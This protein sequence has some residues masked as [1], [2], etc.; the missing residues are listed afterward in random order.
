MDNNA[1]LLQASRPISGTTLTVRESAPTQHAIG[2]RREPTRNNGQTADR[3][4]PEF[5]GPLE[6]RASS[7]T[8]GYQRTF[9]PVTA[10]PMIMRWISEVPSKIV[11]IFASRCQR[12]TGNSRV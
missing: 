8:R 5:T 2:N 3:Q 6:I 10:L 11:K 9:S 1:Y 12:S 7:M 4:K